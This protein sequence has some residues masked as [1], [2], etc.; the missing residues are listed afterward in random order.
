MQEKEANHSI[1]IINDQSLFSDLEEIETLIRRVVCGVLDAEGVPAPTEIS[2]LL[3]DDE[4]IRR[5]NRDFRNIDRKTDVLS[6]PSDEDV[7][8]GDIAI[9]LQTAEEQ[10]K[11]YGHSLAREVGFLTAHS[12]LHLLGYDHMTPEEEKVMFSRQEEILAELNLT[13]DGGELR[14]E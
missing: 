12:V 7:F 5:L 13:R 8:L 4:K 14:R 3:V 2:I 6:F 1:E 9:S 11:E 10:R